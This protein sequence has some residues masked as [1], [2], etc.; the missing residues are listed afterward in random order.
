MSEGYFVRLRRIASRTLGGIFRES[1]A[2]GSVGIRCYVNT[3]LQ[4]SGFSR[5]YERYSSKRSASS[6]HVARSSSCLQTLI[7]SHHTGI[8]KNAYQW[9]S[10]AGGVLYD[11]KGS[12]TSE[13][14]LHS[15]LEHDE[16]AGTVIGVYDTLLPR[17]DQQQQHFPGLA[18]ASSFCTVV[19]LLEG[20]RPLRSALDVLS[21]REDHARCSMTRDAILADLY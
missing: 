21:S 8:F 16:Q 19:S 14:A 6:P 13:S 2:L 18:G 17:S 20:R 9:R 1:S 4:Y 5:S 15:L 7:L 12:A 10:V 11:T 3:V